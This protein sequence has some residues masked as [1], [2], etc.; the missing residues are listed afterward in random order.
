MQV[1]SVVGLQPFH[2]SPPY[3]LIGSL[4]RVRNRLKIFKVYSG[5]RNWGALLLMTS[6][7]VGSFLVKIDDR[8]K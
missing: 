8:S 1:L 5:P 3:L 4:E 6:G 7:H 2:V